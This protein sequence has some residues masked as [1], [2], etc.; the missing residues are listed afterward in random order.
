MTVIIETYSGTPEELA[1]FVGLVWTSSYAGKMTFPKWTP[2]YFRWQ[3]RLIGS[4]RPQNLLAA[5]EGTALVGVLLGTDYSFRTPMGVLPGSLWSWLSIHPDHRGK[6]IAKALD[7]ERVRRQRANGSRLIVSYRY[8]GSK[9]S[10]AERPHTNSFQKRFHAKLG[11]WAR[12]LDP[13]RF[14]RWHYSRVEGFLA[15]LTGPLAPHLRTDPNETKIREFVNQDLDACLTLMQ[16]SQPVAAW[17]V[18][19]DRA[20]L[21]QHLCGSEVSQT[22]ILLDNERI[23]GLINFHVL[24]FQART[25]EKVGVIDLM[26]FRDISSSGRIRLIRTVLSRMVEQNVILALKLRCGDTSAWPMLRT[27]FVPQP[28]ESFLVL[29]WTGDPVE[30]PA[31]SKAHLLWR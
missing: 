19:W 6:G 25:I 2:D 22:L 26:T 11:F 23:S 13:A 29:Q 16:E 1:D 8:V 4:Q 30:I 9:H 21:A 20:S 3:L 10:Q 18:D 7:D 15:R 31:R 12:V 27:G 28:A 5:Y 17:G 24:P 14:A